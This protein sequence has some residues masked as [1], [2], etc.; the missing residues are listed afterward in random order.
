MKYI[1][2]NDLILETKDI[3]SVWMMPLVFEDGKRQTGNGLQIETNGARDYE[4]DY[5]TDEECKKNFKEVWN[6]LEKVTND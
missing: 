4:V 1:K 5:T 6:I 2:F 3:K